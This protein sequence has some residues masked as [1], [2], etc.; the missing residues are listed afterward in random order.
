M[1]AALAASS[2]SALAASVPCPRAG[3]PVLERFVSA[4]CAECW[5]DA[6]QPAPAPGGWLF[7]WITPTLPEAPLAAAAPAE[8]RERALRSGGTAPIGQQ[9]RAQRASPAPL[10]GLKLAVKSGP[11]WSGYFG[12]KLEVQGR[13]PAGSSAWIAL[14]EVL[15][16]GTD[17][18]VVARQLMRTVAGP[19]PLSGSAKQVQLRALR[20]PES[21]EPTRLDARA[22]IEGPDG[23][24]L[25]V[26]SDACALR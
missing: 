22:W 5:R 16:A 1:A 18:S 24:M 23:A 8:A 2:A 21:A 3:A 10:P 4:D 11:A 6:Q 7:D 17:G 15:P 25:A 26:A 19:L 14:V 9:M 12:L 13:L 20:W